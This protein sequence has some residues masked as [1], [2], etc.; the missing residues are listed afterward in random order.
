MIKLDLSR[1]S[2]DLIRERPRTHIHIETQQTARISSI[3]PPIG[4]NS[5][6][7]W[8]EPQEHGWL[9]TEEEVE[10]LFEVI[11]ENNN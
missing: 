11:L 1:K 10:T 7:G 6:I 2:I 8:I 9:F 4:V 5:Y 3:S